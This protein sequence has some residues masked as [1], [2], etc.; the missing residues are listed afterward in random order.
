[1][2]PELL[3]IVKRRSK[4][5]GPQEWLFDE[6]VDER[7]AGDVFGKRFRQYRLKLG[8]DDKQP[9]QRRSLVNFH[10]FRRWF[11]TE[12]ERAGVAESTIS[13]SSVV[14]HEE[15]RKSITLGTYSDGPAWEQMRTCVTSVNLPALKE[16][17][18]VA[19]TAEAA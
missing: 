9:G 6:L 18:E 19:E 14:G 5:K 15:G 11:I 3:E 17:A 12:A 16:A 7:D 10:S 1:M 8:V 2:H 4:G 13:S